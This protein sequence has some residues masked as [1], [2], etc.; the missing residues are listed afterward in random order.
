[1]NTPFAG[2]SPVSPL[3]TLRMLTE[4]TPLPSPL[5]RSTTVFIITSIAGFSSVRSTMIC[6]A[7]NWSRRCSSVT[8]EPK[9]LRNPAS[10]IAESPP[11]TTTIGLPRKKKPSHVAQNETPLPEYSSSP[12]TSRCR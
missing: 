9:R 11:P 6:E 2:S 8:D 5:M 10:S 1:M 3:T 4:V 12:G 7:R